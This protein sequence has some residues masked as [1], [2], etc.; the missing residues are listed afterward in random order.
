[1]GTVTLAARATVLMA[2]ALVLVACAGPLRGMRELPVSQVRTTPPDN[3]AAIIFLRPSTMGYAI[4]SSVFE[5]RDD[6]ERFIGTCLPRKSSSI[7]W[8]RAGDAS[9]S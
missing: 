6:G 5:L 7:M 8:R 4:A 9:W 2:M 3:Q 1:M